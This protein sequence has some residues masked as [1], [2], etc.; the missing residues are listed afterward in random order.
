M[1]ETYIK[2]QLSEELLEEKDIV[3]TSPDG[4]DN[5]IDGGEIFW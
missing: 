2:P 5:E 1:K 4:E 3:T